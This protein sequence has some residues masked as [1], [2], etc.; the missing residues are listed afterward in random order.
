[1]AKATETTGAQVAEG[2]GSSGRELS[3]WGD[4]LSL[5]DATPYCIVAPDGTVEDPSVVID[6]ELLRNL[7]RSMAITRGLDEESIALQRQGQLGVY[8]SSRGQE[9]C[10]VGPA[11]A[12]TRG[13]D[14]L[15]PA[16]RELGAAVVWGVDAADVL[17]MWRG[18]WFSDY[19]VTTLR[20]GMQTVPVA[21]Q[22]LHAAGYAMGMRLD[23]HAGAVL[24]FIGDGA[25]SEGDFHEALNFAATWRVPCVFVVQ[26]NRYAISVPYEE[27]T[28]AHRIAYRGV[29]YGVPAVVVDGND[30]LAC[31]QV[32]ATALE[33]ARAGGG[34]SLIEAMTFRMES[35]T[36]SDDQSRYRSDEL[37]RE[38]SDRDPLLRV[39][40]L[41][42]RL[43]AWE[44]LE[45]EIAGDVAAG[46]AELRARI[47]DAPA[48]DPVEVF[49]TVYV[50]AAGHFEDQVDQ[51]EAELAASQDEGFR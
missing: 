18:T 25:T 13:L 38:W 37:L 29:G 43:D 33:R 50:D 10:Q 35:H 40:R 11:S 6:T 47:F 17:H 48:P 12:L 49:R 26:N 22:L 9:A 34:P 4:A 2:D 32:V 51:L 15:M 28:A 24:T 8:A 27:Q 44:G 39:Q 16:Y 3:C 14:W 19:D 31:R 21:T 42:E 36:T 20:Y 7:Y 23:D 45:A 46:R 1:M 41:L 5:P 30:V